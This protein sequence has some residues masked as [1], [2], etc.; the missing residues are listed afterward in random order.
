MTKNI[1][2]PVIGST[3]KFKQ[4]ESASFKLYDAAITAARSKFNILSGLTCL[5]NF[6]SPD[7]RIRVRRRIANGVSVFN[8]ISLR[9]IDMKPVKNIGV[10]DADES[11][12]KR[13]T[14]KGGK[15]YHKRLKEKT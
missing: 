9:R 15:K 6:D 1:T 7:Y 4:F 3:A 12:D 10:N 11:T 13:N 8:V 14:R 5:D 2:V